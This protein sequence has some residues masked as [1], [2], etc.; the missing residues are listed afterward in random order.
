MESSSRKR[1][2]TIE[3]GKVEITTKR[4][5]GNTTR[6]VD[7]AI[8]IMFSGDIC[9]VLDHH[10][11]G[12]NRD[13]NVYLLKKIVARLRAE[14]EVLFQIDAVRIDRNKLEIFLDI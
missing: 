12:R 9:V 8:Q 14:H 6:L 4:R 3:G 1:T 10:E 2:T 11:H 13:A 5:D 7:H